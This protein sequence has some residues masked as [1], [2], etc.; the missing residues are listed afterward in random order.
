MKSV[1]ELKLDEDAGIMGARLATVQKMQAAAKAIEDKIKNI[2]LPT[3]LSDEM[4]A[5]I[6][7]DVALLPH[8]PENGAGGVLLPFPYWLNFFKLITYFSQIA[9]AGFNKNFAEIRREFMK[10]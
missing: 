6:R 9:M 4:K 8:C 1:K 3:D 10:K 7:A 2:D 5:L